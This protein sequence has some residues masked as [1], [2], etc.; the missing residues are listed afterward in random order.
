MLYVVILLIMWWFI[1]MYVI[2]DAEDKYRCA[3]VYETKESAKKAK[4][5]LDKVFKVCMFFNILFLITA[6]IVIGKFN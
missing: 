2:N 5:K 4:I 3:V 1:S 6:I